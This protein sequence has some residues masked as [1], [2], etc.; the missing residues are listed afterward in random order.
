MAG[1][2]RLSA[3]E[4]KVE[5]LAKLRLGWTVRKCMEQVGKSE[6]TWEYYLRSDS[7]FKE[8]VTQIRRRL[9]DGETTIPNFQQFSEQF[10]GMRLFSHQLQW[11]D[12]LDGKAPRNLHPAQTYEQNDPD[13]ILVNTPP[14]HAKTMTISTNYVTYRI[15]EDPNIRVLVISATATQANKILSAIKDRLSSKTRMFEELKE[16]FAP[17]DGYD[18]NGAMWRQNMIYVNPD[19]RTRGEKDPTVQALGIGQHIY[20]ARAD[21]IILDDCVDIDNAHEYEKQI[22]WIQTIVRSRLEPYSGKLVIVG[23]RLKAQDLYEEI[24]KPQ[25]YTDGQSP[26]TYLTQPAVLEPADD[27]AD[28]VVIWPKTNVK[29]PGKHSPEPDENGLFPRWPGNTLARI[30]SGMS[31]DR[32]A[33]VYMQAQISESMTFTPAMVSG[34]TN[35]SRVPG[36]MVPGQRGHRPDGMLGLYVIAGLDPAPTNYTAAVVLG[37]DRQSGRR[38]LLDVW[39]KHGALPREIR[40]LV[41]AWTTRYGILEWRIEDNGL[42]KYIAQDEEILKWCRSRGTGVFGHLTNQNKWDSQFG[43]ATMANMFLGSEQGI[44]MLELPSRRNHAGMMALVEQLVSWYPTQ[45]Q[46]KMPT[47]DCVMALWF[48]ELRARHIAD[49]LDGTTHLSSPY[50][51]SIESEQQVTIDIDAFLARQH[52]EGPGVTDFN[53]W[54]KADRQH[55]GSGRWW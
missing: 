49:E 39:N 53:D 47:Q 13:M 48:A 16:A 14:D 54:L 2:D 30:R 9:A 51:S 25:H 15:V 5:I 23:T 36:I 33:R 27:P 46:N 52:T 10:F 43:V 3:D 44:N 32:W 7:V 19:L 28:W 37:V 24:R 6:K 40:E 38:Y 8:T 20:G 1:P 55:Q 12:L 17:S 35:E 45:G 26:W 41:Q 42:N 31:S 18:G 29:P 50:R 21:L 22:E 11:L 34:C 4:A